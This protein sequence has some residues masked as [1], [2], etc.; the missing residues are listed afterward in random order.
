MSANP[1]NVDLPKLWWWD[2]RRAR[3]G[4]EDMAVDECLLASG[5]D[6]PVL[7][8]YRWS[9]PAVSFGY[10]EP[11]APILARFPSPDLCFVRRW[12][13]GGV[14]E[15]G[16]D[17]TYTIV[18]PKLAA[19]DWQNSVAV[20]AAIH[21]LLAQ[22][23][24]QLGMQAVCTGE[25]KQSPGTLCFAAP[26]RHDVLVDGTKVAGA[27]QR[28]TSDGILHQGSLQGPAARA[29]VVEHLAHL[30]SP[31]VDALPAPLHPLDAAVSHIAATRYADQSWTFAR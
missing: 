28:R 13:G 24:C 22:A 14:V 12:T 9:R 5:L 26:V 6:R 7:R 20:Y 8:A 19:P 31:C 25:G 21:G 30:C 16:H 10:A 3:S 1:S 2:D 17:M 4:P 29:E 23:L 15:H 11:I 27:G 18:L